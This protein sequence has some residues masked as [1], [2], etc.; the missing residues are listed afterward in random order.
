MLQVISLL[1]LM[2]TSFQQP[3]SVQYAACA[4]RRAANKLSMPDQDYG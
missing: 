3:S 4:G 2:L 1:A